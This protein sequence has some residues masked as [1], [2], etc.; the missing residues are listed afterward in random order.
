MT[1][2]DRTPAEVGRMHALQRLAEAADHLAARPIPTDLAPADRD[3]LTSFVTTARSVAARLRNSP[4]Y[5]P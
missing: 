3:Y 4:G 5:E 1:A 2:G